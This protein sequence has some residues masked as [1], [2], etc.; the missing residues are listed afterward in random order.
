METNPA[1]ID[2]FV[3]DGDVVP[4]VEGLAT[5]DTWYCVGVW[6]SMPDNSM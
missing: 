3:P 2:T 4:P 1:D 5:N 6:F